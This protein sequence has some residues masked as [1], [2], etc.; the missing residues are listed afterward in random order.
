[1]ERPPN[2]HRSSF[3]GALDSPNTDSFAVGPSSAPLPSPVAPFMRAPVDL[4]EQRGEPDDYRGDHPSRP[5]SFY[6]VDRHVRPVSSATD[7]RGSTSS[8][9]SGPS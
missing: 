6:Q 7:I 5:S 1:M 9:S 8:H 2:P 4:R 3:F